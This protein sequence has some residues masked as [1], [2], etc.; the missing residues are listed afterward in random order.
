[1]LTQDPAQE[2]VS[3]LNMALLELELQRAAELARATEGAG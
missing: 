3:S 2:L 1:L